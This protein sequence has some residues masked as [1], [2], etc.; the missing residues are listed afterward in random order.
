[1]ENYRSISEL[2]VFAKIIE[3]LV[4]VQ[5]SASLKL[6]FT[7]NQHRILKGRFTTSNLV[8]CSDYLSEHMDKRSQVG[9]VYTVF[10]SDGGV[11]NTQTVIDW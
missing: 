3:K 1:M 4:H 8:V 7:E 2:C 10:R 11:S 9:V 6:S 5:L